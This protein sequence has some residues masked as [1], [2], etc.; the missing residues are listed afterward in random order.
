MN[1]RRPNGRL[2]AL[3]LLAAPAAGL[4][5]GPSVPAAYRDAAAGA[6]VGAAVF[7][8]MAL[9]ESGQGGMTAEYRPW[10]WTLSVDGEPRYFPTRAGAL[11]ALTAAIRRRPGQLG[12][13]L[14]QIEHR[15]HA[16]R[17]ESP[18]Q[19]LDPYANARVAAEILAEGLA[20]AGGDVWEAVGR[21]HSNTPAL[22][23]AYRVRVAERL[24]G[25]VGGPD[26]GH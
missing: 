22:A 8:A 10:P 5:Q 1:R 16:H 20:A 15:F 26:H 2:L 19:M 25:L 12:V 18:G 13:G 21:F 6:R 14:F 4:A 7:Y 3:L 17:F 9:T 23:D 24:V 11:D